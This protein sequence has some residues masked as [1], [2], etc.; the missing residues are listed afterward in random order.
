VTEPI[1]PHLTPEQIKAIKLSS[2]QVAKIDARDFVLV[3]NHTW[4]LDTSGYPRAN[5]KLNGKWSLT[6]LH[7]FLIDP[8][9]GMFVDHIDCDKLNNARSNLRVCTPAQSIANIRKY[10]G[11]STFKGVHWHKGAGKWMAQIKVSGR[12]KYL[13]LFDIEADAGAA[14]AAAAISTH[15]EFARIA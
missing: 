11:R 5:L 14:Y 9:P 1:T 6:R 12:H 7:R 15:G 8:L 10:A 3:S 4:H 13:G 2:G